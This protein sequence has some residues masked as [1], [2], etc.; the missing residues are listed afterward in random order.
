MD[1]D[2]SA[3]GSELRVKRAPV[4]KSSFGMIS[5]RQIEGTDSGV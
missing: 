4:Q 1:D 5:S 2:P 3:T